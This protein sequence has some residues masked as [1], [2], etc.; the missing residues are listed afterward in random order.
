MLGLEFVDVSVEKTRAAL[1]S[2]SN[3]PR[4]GAFRHLGTALSAD[5]HPRREDCGWISSQGVPWGRG[6]RIS[7]FLLVSF[8]QVPMLM[9][10]KLLRR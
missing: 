8:A 9:Q 10:D 3:E 1:P 2:L 5:R 7:S 4:P 6:L